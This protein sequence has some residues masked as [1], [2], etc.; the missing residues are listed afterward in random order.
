MAEKREIDLL[1][2]GYSCRLFRDDS[3]ALAV[4]EQDNLVAW[5]GNPDLLMDR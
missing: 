2:F 1:V 4:N 5:Q 3:M